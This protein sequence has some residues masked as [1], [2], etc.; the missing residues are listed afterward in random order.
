MFFFQ[1]KRSISNRRE[2]YGAHYDEGRLTRK[3][4]SDPIWATLAQRSIARYRSLEKESG[5]DF[6]TEVGTLIIG[7]EGSD[8]MS[9]N[10][11]VIK[12]QN[13][14]IDTLTFLDMKKKFPYLNVSDDDYGMM[15]TTDAGYISPRSLV[16]A[17]ITVAV[18]N[19]CIYNPDV[20][21]DVRR[22]VEKGNYLMVVQTD[23]NTIFAK[24]V[25]LAT[26][27][28][29]PFRNILPSGLQLDLRLRPITVAKVKISTSDY[30][31]LR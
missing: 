30:K 23:R 20:V 8:Y 11:S 17:Q 14:K 2:I 12:E 13:L 21:N 27:A 22:I 1:E 26:G 3:L 10:E 25:L 19:G 15:E 28:F 5:I 16:K 29:T 4:A 6:Y 18:K 9:K 31:D 24:R 7:T